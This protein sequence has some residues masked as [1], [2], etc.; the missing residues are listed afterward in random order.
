MKKPILSLLALLTT[1][2]VSHGSVVYRETFGNSKGADTFL[3]NINSVW[4]V[5]N[6]ASGLAV[7]ETAALT[8]IHVSKGSGTPTDLPNIGT[9]NATLSMTNGYAISNAFVTL[10]ETTEMTLDATVPTT[11]SWYQRNTNSTAL[12]R[13]V[14][15][16]GNAWYA[17]SQTF[18]NTAAAASAGTFTLESFTF[19]TAASSWRDLNFVAGTSMSLGAVR[20]ADLPTGD[21]TGFGLLTADT[22][23]QYQRFDTFTVDGVAVPEPSVVGLLSLAAGAGFFLRK[24][25]RFCK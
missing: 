15:Q 21:I 4:K 13:V 1:L 7:D 8:S 22:A 3:S 24:K 25:V 9:K 11:F 2:A 12:D 19:T 10:F 16:I 17:T 18:T 6:G 5:Y 20:T 23:G 14:V